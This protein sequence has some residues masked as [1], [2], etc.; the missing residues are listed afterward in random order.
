MGQGGQV[1]FDV[2]ESGYHELA[3]LAQNGQGRELWVV[4]FEKADV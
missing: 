4:V 1:K 2:D 3:N